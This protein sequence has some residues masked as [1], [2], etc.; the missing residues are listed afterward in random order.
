MI[1]ENYHCVCCLFDSSQL[2]GGTDGI[3]AVGGGPDGGCETCDDVNP[4]TV[5]EVAK[6]DISYIYHKRIQR[7]N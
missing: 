1:F 4:G 7:C 6:T 5:G 3:G 2:G